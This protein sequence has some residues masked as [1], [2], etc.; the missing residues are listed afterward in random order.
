[1]STE[2]TV[3]RAIATQKALTARIADFALNVDYALSESNAVTKI[4]VENRGNLL[5]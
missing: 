3:T 5:V 1:M 2:M 4:K